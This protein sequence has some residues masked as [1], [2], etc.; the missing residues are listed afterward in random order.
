MLVHR[1]F[2]VN[3]VSLNC[4]HHRNQASLLVLHRQ[5]TGHRTKQLFSFYNLGNTNVID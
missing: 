2:G 5:N 4:F 1:L 3:G